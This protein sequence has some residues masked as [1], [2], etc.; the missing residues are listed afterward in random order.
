MHGG[1]FLLPFLPFL[2]LT[3]TTTA[4]AAGGKSSSCRNWESFSQQEKKNLFRPSLALPNTHSLFFFLSGP[5]L[6][7]ARARVFTRVT[8]H[9]FLFFFFKSLRHVKRQGCVE[10]RGEETG[11]GVVVGANSTTTTG[12]T[13]GNGASEQHQQHQQSGGSE[14]TLLL[15]GSCDMT[16]CF[17]IVLFLR[18]FIHH[19]G[20]FFFLVLFLFLEGTPEELRPQ[21]FSRL[22]CCRCCCCC[23]LLLHRVAFSS[24]ILG[25]P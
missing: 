2:V 18:R 19:E 22:P 4:A 9:F 15:W 14:R 25:W 13:T 12:T 10:G 11:R 5:M 16:S 23:W 1:F 3:T 20:F 6:C 21:T 8:A 7:C 24:R 17:I